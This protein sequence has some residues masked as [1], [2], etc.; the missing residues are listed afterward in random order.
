MRGVFLDILDVPADLAGR[1]WIAGFPVVF[2]AS[3][4]GRERSELGFAQSAE[5]PTHN[6]EHVYFKG[7]VC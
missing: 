2:D 7:A 4:H 5:I 1:I 3:L 6:R